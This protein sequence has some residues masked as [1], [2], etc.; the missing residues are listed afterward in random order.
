MSKK[1][2][3]QKGQSRKMSATEV[4]VSTSIGYVVAIMSQEV[5]FPMFGIWVP[6]KDNLLIGLFFTIVSVIR[7]YLVRR[8]FNSIGLK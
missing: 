7:G 6:F 5:I 3:K 4:A 2:C 8:M 1:R